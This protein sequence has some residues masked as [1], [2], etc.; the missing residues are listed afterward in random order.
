M[1]FEMRRRFHF[2]EYI[3]YGTQHTSRR[4]DRCII[5]YFGYLSTD[6]NTQPNP[7]ITAAP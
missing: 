4:I 2:K 5:R 1:I 6:E 3:P 7:K